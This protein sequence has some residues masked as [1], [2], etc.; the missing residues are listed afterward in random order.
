MRSEYERRF[1]AKKE[2]NPQ[3]D[4][5]EI[6]LYLTGDGDKDRV[7]GLTRAEDL[8]RGANFT[9]M[10]Q[11]GGNTHKG[12]AYPTF[13]QA[14]LKDKQVWSACEN[15]MDAYQSRSIPHPEADNARDELNAYIFRAKGAKVAD[16]V[17]ILKSLS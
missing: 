12:S 16:V 4:D 6:Y 3:A 1:K 5:N 11:D 17:K 10:I 13:R 7:G 9:F 14:V 8:L 2:E 15:L